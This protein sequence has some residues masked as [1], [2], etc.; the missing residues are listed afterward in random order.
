MNIP[1]QISRR[2]FLRGAGVTLA[3]PL[4]DAML[5]GGRAEETK[6]APPRRLICIDATLGLHA[7]NF[8]PRETGRDY[9]LTPY[10]EVVKDFREDFTVFSGLSHPEVDGGHASLASFLSSAPHP[11]AA[12]FRNTVTLDQFAVEKLVPDTRFTSLQL[13]SGKTSNSISFTSAGVM[14]PAEEKPSALFR[15]LFV[16]GTPGEVETEMGRLRQGGSI[17]DTV[18]G[19]ARR[20]QNNLGTRDREKLDEY[21]TSV[22]EVEQ[23]LHRAQDWAQKPKPA[24]DVA[25]PADIPDPAD[26]VGR[27]KAMFNLIHLALQTDSTRFVTLNLEGH[28]L[29]PPIEGVSIDWHSLSHHGQS[30][31]KL[32][33]LRLLELAQMETLAGLLGEL[34]QSREAGGTLLDRTM[35]LFGSNLGNASSHDTRNLPVLL[36]GGGFK[37]GQHLAFDRAHNEPLANLYVTMLQRLGVE[38]EKFGSG[39]GTLRGFERV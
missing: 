1:R 29:V 23:R 34:R 24:V 15:R 5:P 12:S 18:L 19:E 7:A 31:E 30:P 26:L 14:I 25:P 33:Q 27:T 13:T 2:T 9:A 17:M 20:F 4:L 38:A 10:L 3:L 6:S 21:F 16:N 11:A 28:N 39:T 22:R 35:V 8:F 32:A 37:H 36:A